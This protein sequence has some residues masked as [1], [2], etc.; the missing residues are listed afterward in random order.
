MDPVAERY[1]VRATWWQ[2]RQ[3]E[4]MD[5]SQCRV[6]AHNGV[7]MRD[8]RWFTTKPSGYLVEPQNQDRR[9]GRRRWY[10]GALRSFDAGGHVMSRGLASVGRRLRQRCGRPMKNVHYLT[11]LPMRGVYL[12]LSYRVAWSF[13]PPGETSYI[14]IYIYIWQP[15]HP[16]VTT[17]PG[18]YRTIA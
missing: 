4:V 7:C 16:D 5:I 1:Q 2:E 14:Y 9:L 13:A 17:R 3:D 8:L 15:I 18:K 10:P 6:A 11:I 12:I